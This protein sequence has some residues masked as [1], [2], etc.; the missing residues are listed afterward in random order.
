MLLNRGAGPANASVTC[1]WAELGLPAG[2]A[3]AVRDLWAHADLGPATGAF[4]ATVPPH[5]C[6]MVRVTPTT[7]LP[8]RDGA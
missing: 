3:A 8:G 4:T 5:G 7:W 1:T 6:V 2:E